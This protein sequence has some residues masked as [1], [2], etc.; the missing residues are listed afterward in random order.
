MVDNLKSFITVSVFCEIDRE[1]RRAGFCGPVGPLWRNRTFV[2]ITTVVVND[3]RNLPL[4][5]L[6]THISLNVK[7]QSG[8]ALEWLFLLIYREKGVNIRAKNSEIGNSS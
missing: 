3:E 7:D 1:F 6:H 2:F 4:G 8:G 5:I